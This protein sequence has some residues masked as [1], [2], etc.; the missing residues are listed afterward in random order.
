VAKIRFAKWGKM[1]RRKMIGARRV[2]LRGKKFIFRKQVSKVHDSM[3]DEKKM[4]M[5]NLYHSLKD[6]G[7]DLDE[8][9]NKS[10]YELEEELQMGHYKVVNVP[11]E[12]SGHILLSRVPGTAIADD[13]EYLKKFT[14]NKKK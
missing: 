10:F 11:I 14:E 12:R 8:I 4:M 9:K 7:F 6:A 5:K 2:E 1:N 13:Y 3:P